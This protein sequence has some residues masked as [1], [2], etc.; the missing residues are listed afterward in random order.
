MFVFARNLQLCLLCLDYLLVELSKSPPPLPLPL[1]P[2]NE[3]GTHGK[4]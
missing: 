4:S 3:T 2:E 1:N